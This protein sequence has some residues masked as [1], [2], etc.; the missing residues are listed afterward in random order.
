[1]GSFNFH[2]FFS[3]SIIKTWAIDLEIILTLLLLGI[4]IPGSNPV[5]EAIE[6]PLGSA[7]SF[8]YLGLRPRHGADLQINGCKESF[9]QIPQA[10][11][12]SPDRDDAELPEGQSTYYFQQSIDYQ[13]PRFPTYQIYSWLLA[14]HLPLASLLAIPSRQQLNINHRI[15]SIIQLLSNILHS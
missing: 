5:N 8:I 4:R 1:M 14:K 13:S 3:L 6:M 7:H 9:S 10:L 12:Q 15:K 11:T 2:N